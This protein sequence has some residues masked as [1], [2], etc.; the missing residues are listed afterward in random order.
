MLI[1]FATLYFLNMFQGFM[2]GVIID[3]NFLICH[4]GSFG[5]KSLQNKSLNIERNN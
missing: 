1:V 2:N 5:M 3:V 4:F